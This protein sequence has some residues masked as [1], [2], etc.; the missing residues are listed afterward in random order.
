MDSS[1]SLALVQL[2][3]D[4][5][6][7]AIDTKEA[8]SLEKHAKAICD[9]VERVRRT[10]AEGVM[11]LG[12]ELTAAHAK[13]S[14]HGDGTFG[15]WCSLR[16]GLTAR[17]ARNMMGVCDTFKDREMISQSADPTALY[18]LSAPSCPEEATAEALERAEQG[19]RITTKLARDIIKSHPPR[20]N[21]EEPDADTINLTNSG[22]DV[23]HGDCLELMQEMAAGSV[24]LVFG[25]PP[26][27]DARTYGISFDLVGDAWVDW[28]F[29]R[30]M[31]SLRV[32]KG[33][34]AFV[35]EGKTKQYRWSATPVL[36]MA[37]LHQAGVHLRKPV[38]YKRQGIPGAGGPDWLRLA[39]LA[40]GAGFVASVAA[41]LWPRIRGGTRR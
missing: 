8:K 22:C 29:E 25:S 18:L 39:E 6:A 12:A 23:R 38:I 10:T 13:L 5:E 7:N 35:V 41:L 14:N 3:F 16:C 40:A 15:K 31:E 32:C 30:V 34:V 36:L 19:E 4:Y 33:L 28:M 17:H 9:T 1:R 21:R 2:S 37:K 24:D 20:V 11:K 27:E 26:Y